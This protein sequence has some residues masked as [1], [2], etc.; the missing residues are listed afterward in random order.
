MMRIRRVWVFACAAMAAL[1]PLTPAAADNTATM[2]IPDGSAGAHQTKASPAGRCLIGPG[3]GSSLLIPY[4]E[5]DLADPNGVTT[6]FSVNNGFSDP[7]LTRVVLWSDWGVPTMGF[8]IYLLGFDVQTI[9]VRSIL[10]GIL[11]STGAGADLSPWPYCDQWPPTYVNPALTSDEIEHLRD[12]HTGQA[13]EIDGLC[14][15]ADHGDQVARGFITV[16]VVDECS[17]VEGWDP[18]WVPT[19]TDYPYFE[20]GGDPF[21]IA[22]VDNR[23]WGDVIY[24]DFTNNSAQ[25]SEAVSLWADPAEFSGS[26]VFTFYGRHSGY[27][28]RDERV[29]LPYRWDQRFLNGGAFA[30]GADLIVFQQPNSMAAQP[31]SCLDTP[32]WYP[33]LTEVVS[34]DEQAGNIELL[35]DDLFPNVTQRVSIN[36]ISPSVDFGWMQVTSDARQVWVQPSLT[37]GGRFSAGFN[38]IPVSFLCDTVPPSP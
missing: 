32:G 36:E 35:A 19:N 3:L 29:P 13:S 23:L 18:I 24:V 6:L 5:V 17:N 34:L 37:A 21:G 2:V 9:D 11:P 28:G 15:G 20:E 26:D 4:F 14:Y 31:I 22:I 8:D 27:D 7:T 12:A 38:G 16:D 30:G 1:V 25:G 10:G 33:L